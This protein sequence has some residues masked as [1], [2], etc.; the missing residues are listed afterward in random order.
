MSPKEYPVISPALKRFLSDCSS[1][2]FVKVWIFFTDKGVFSQKQYQQAKATFKNSLTGSALKRRLKN[3]VEI[4]FLDLPINQNYADEVL[5][6]GG[7]FRKR[8]RWLNA[9][10]LQIQVDKIERI[11]QLPF[12]RKIKKVVSFKRKPPKI[13]PIHGKLCREK[14]LAGYGRRYGSS[15]RQ[16]DQINVPVV[17]DIGFKGENVIVGMLDTGYR[18]DHQVFASAY[19]E[20][21]V[22][23]EWDFINDDGNTQNEG[24]D[25]SGQHDHGTYTWSA[26][27][28]E[29]D[30]ELYGPAFK[31]SFVLAKTEDISGEEPIEED[32]WVAGLE[33][34]DSIGAEVASSSLGYTDWYTYS[35]FDGNTCVTTIAADIAASRGIVVCNAMGNDGPGDGTLIAPADA[36]SILACGA[37][38]VWGDIAGFSSRGPTY[39]ER[40]KPEVVARGVDTYC[41][42]ALGI[43]Q[44]GSVNGT[45]LST[46]LVAGCAAVLLS[47][48]PDWTV[49]QVR[50]ALMMTANNASSPDNTYG[51]GLVNL[52]AALNYNPSGALTIQHDPP[53][54]TSDTQNPYIMSATITPGNGL[55]EDSL[56]L[57]W[58]SDTFSPFGKQGLQSLGS[59]QYQAE[60]PAQSAGTILHYYFSAQDSLNNVVNFPLGAPRFKFKLYVATDFITF[61]FEDG[62]FHWE[63]GGVNNQWCITSNDSSQ[64]TFRLT[65]SPPAEYQNNTDS[66]AGIKKTFDLT[67]VE[68]PQLSFWHRY[69]FWSGDSGFVE[70]NLDGGKNWERLCSA[71][72]STQGGW[73][74]VSLPLDA[75]TGHTNVKFRFRLISDDEGTGDGWYIDEVQVNFKPTSV[76]EEPAS[77]PLQFSLDQNY[78]NPFNPTTTIPFTVY[79]SRFMV[80]SPS[81]TTLKVYNVLGQKV[82]ILV[83]EEMMPGNYQVIWDGKDNQGKEVASGIYFYQLVT[84]N[85]GV[86]KKMMLLK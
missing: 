35:D 31:A 38:D 36:D 27:G 25:P 6:L 59:D 44:Y 29:Y 33:W 56:F 11:A 69:Q 7:K 85:S 13:E 74:Q 57:F 14:E 43:D 41:A 51:W 42:S 37:V 76:E 52:F 61:D 46:P 50:K 23:A 49:M 17:H 70:I 86:T 26:L 62:F 60:I 78:P 22:L 4:D 10:S 40:I 34:A 67:D 83:D 73:T 53:L 39:D 55:S 9:I 71:F 28:G 79:G 48:H 54:F 1:E 20:S 16:L 15:C 8:S 2:D 66:W 21:R 75:Y 63:T 19:S 82:R 47:A 65:D 80:H 30:G 45:S 77:I 12:V 81:H 58:R 72:D 5:K 32:N 68:N 84:E 64:G 24:G 18:K 3:K